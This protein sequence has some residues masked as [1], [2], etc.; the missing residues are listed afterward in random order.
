MK[1]L[2]LSTTLFLLGISSCKSIKN[3]TSAIKNSSTVKFEE[4][5]LENGLHV[6][7]HQDNTAPVVV[8]SVMYRVGSKDDPIGRTG[9]AH[10]FEHLLFEGSENVKRG[11]FDMYLDEVGAMNNANTSFDR[12]YYYEIAPSNALERTLWL[13]SERMLHAKVEKEGIETQRQVVKEER[14]LRYDNQPYATFIEEISKRLYTVHPYSHTPIGSMEDLDKAEEK[15]YKNFYKTYYVP[16]NAVLVLAGAINIKNASVLV[17]RYFKDIPRGATPPRVLIQEP[18]QTKEIRAVVEDAKAPL[19]AIFMAYHVPKKGDPESYKIEVLNKVLV[20][21]ASSRLYKALV[22]SE[23]AMESFAFN[24]VL[25]DGGALIIGAIANSGIEADVLE[26]IINEEIIKLQKD[27]ITD[28]ELQKVKNQFE[29]DYVNQL[30]KLE[31]RAE[32][33]AEYHT[34]HNKNTAL[35]NSE[36]EKYLSVTKEDVQIM[37]KKYLQSN[38]R[39]V[40]NWIPK[41]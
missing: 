20:E 14:R 26:K 19:P 11:A 38:N 28:T 34:F 31:D 29:N 25:E 17:K 10:F 37:A 33:L 16:N 2:L 8:T 41:K 35:I 12:T 39:V 36:L 40:L 22:N 27:L 9:F 23:K 1:Y 5:D 7:L 32:L 30:D 3:K 24:Y 21:G 15:D 6:I 4:F 13:E 18:V